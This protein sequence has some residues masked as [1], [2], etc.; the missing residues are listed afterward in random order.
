MIPESP[1]HRRTLQGL[2]AVL[3]A[4]CLGGAGPAQAQGVELASLRASRTETSIDLEFAA[5]VILPRAVDEAL[6][7]GVPIYFTAEATLLRQRWYWRDERVARISR[8]WRIA[9]QPLTGSWRVGLGGL[10]QTH[11]SLAEALSAASRS[12]GWKLADLSQVD[13]DKSY[14]VAFE[15][16]LDTALLPSPMQFGLSLQGDWAVGVT[17]VVPVR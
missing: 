11:H 17:R 12:A 6:A 13:P 4:V 10:N 2:A 16:R 15:Y 1:V 8:T 7:R 3:A 14:H 9:F 5:R